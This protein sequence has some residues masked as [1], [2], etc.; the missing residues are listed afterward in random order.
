MQQLS[1]LSNLAIAP[2]TEAPIFTK[3]YLDGSEDAAF[4][5]IPQRNDEDYLAGYL[6]AVRRLPTNQE[7][8]IQ[9]YSPQ[10]HFAYGWLDSPDE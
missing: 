10:Q 6:A 5:Q 4:G 3:G 1:K 7:G 9:H 2:T 8:K